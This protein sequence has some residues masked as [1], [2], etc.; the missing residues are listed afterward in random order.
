MAKEI[1]VK[2]T[3]KVKEVEM[4]AGIMDFS[5]AQGEDGPDVSGDTG[6]GN[7]SESKFHF[8][9]NT[10]SSSSIDWDD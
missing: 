5:F 4:E 1:Y 6:H 3:I 9:D 7:P 8:L 2:P 10:E